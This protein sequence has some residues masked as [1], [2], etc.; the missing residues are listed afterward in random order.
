[1]KINGSESSSAKTAATG[2]ALALLLACLAAPAPARAG[3]LYVNDFGTPSMANAGAGAGAIANDASAALHAPAGMTRLDR[4]QV[5]L[6]LAPGFATIEFDPD[7]DTPV[8]GTDGGEQS[9]FIPVTSSSYAHKLSDRFRLGLSVVSLSGAVLGPEDTWVGRNEVT[10][11]SLFTLTM[12]PSIAA[13]VTDW[14]SLSVGPVITYGSLTQKLRAPVGPGLGP[15]VRLDDLDDWAA[16]ALVS[17][18]FEVSPK[19]R[20]SVVWQSEIE[21]DLSGDVEIPPAVEAGL[22]LKLPLVQAIRVSSYWDVTDRLAFLT[23]FAWEDW[24]AAKDLPVSVARGQAALPLGFTDTFKV[25]VGFNYRVGERWL[26]QTGFSHDT[27][28]LSSGDRTTAFPIDRQLRLGLGAQYEFSET[29]RMG[30]AFSWTNLGRAPVK[31]D[32]VRGSYKR[33]DLFLFGVTLNMKELPWSHRGT[34]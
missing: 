7:D 12:L 5:L 26:L 16:G 19:L 13:R 24:S 18:L 9:G 10:K 21:L 1:V 32:F 31:S 25:G 17:G 3:G 11:L 27:N 33:N 20:F 2:A 30:F 8:A 15:E 34:W 22:E 14:L 29:M 28:P 23:N 6:G 4:H